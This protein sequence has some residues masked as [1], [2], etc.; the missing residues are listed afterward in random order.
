MLLYIENEE[1]RLPGDII[2]YAKF[3]HTV[4]MRTLSSKP[5]MKI[6]KHQ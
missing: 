6:K 3:L 4:L 5:V 2:I 1:K